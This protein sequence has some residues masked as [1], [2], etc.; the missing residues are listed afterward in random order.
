MSLYTAYWIA[1]GPHGPRSLPPPG[2]NKKVALY[3]GIGILASFVLF[4][5][6]RSFA[7]PPPATMTKEYQEATNEF[8]KVSALCSLS[9]PLQL[10]DGRWSLTGLLSIG[11]KLG[12][13]DWS[14]VG[15]LLGQGPR[16]IPLVQGINY[17]RFLL[18]I[19]ATSCRL[20][21]AARACG[22]SARAAEHW[23]L[24]GL[25]LDGVNTVQR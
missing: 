24:Q 5:T 18:L 13:V 10:T 2:E 17:T 16:A 12:P 14:R 25:I 23:G 3:T 1:F 20:A 8:L 15:R 22:G 7:R 21:R 11:S 9:Y 19:D 6:A 4:A